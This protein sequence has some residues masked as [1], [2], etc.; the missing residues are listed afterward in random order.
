MGG[1]EAEPAINPNKRLRLCHQGFS[2]VQN[3]VAYAGTALD[4]WLAS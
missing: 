1:P 2:V 3:C 4:G